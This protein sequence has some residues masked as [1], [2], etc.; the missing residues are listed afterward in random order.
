MNP[1]TSELGIVQGRIVPQVYTPTE[2][3]YA[4]V[5]GSDTPGYIYDFNIDDSV[6]INQIIDVTGI[7]F[8]RLDAQFRSPEMPDGVYWVFRMLIDNFPYAWKLL[9]PGKII[10][11]SDMA[12]NVSKLAG[13]VILSL[14][15]TLEAA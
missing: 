3:E 8:I 2:G 10:N 9:T 12:A 7:N 4:F 15:L 11:S 13:P 6:E 5:L 14:R 1:F